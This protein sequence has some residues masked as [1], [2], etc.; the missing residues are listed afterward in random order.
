MDAADEIVRPLQDR[1][2][3]VDRETLALGYAG[4][5]SSFRITSYNVCYTKLLRRWTQI[6]T[7]YAGGVKSLADMERLQVLGKNRLDATIGSAL[8]IFG[9]KGT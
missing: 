8:D 7:T 2:V 5:Y 6:P 4:V 1:P 3:R 9:G